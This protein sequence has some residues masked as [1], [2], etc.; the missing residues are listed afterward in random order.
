MA[1]TWSDIIVNN[2][3]VVID[4]VRLTEEL[5]IDAAQF[6]RRM[7]MYFSMAL[8]L[9]SRPPEL[10]QYLTNGLIEA[11]YTDSEWVS[12]AESLEQETEVDTGAVGYELCSCVLRTISAGEVIL[13]PYAVTYDA[14]TGIVTF[15]KQDSEGAEYILDFYTDGKFA[16]DLTETQKRIIGL[17]VAIVWDER[18]TRNWLNMQMKIKD[19]SF[20]TVNESNYLEKT[21]YRM[22]ENRAAFN[23]ELRKYEQD[24]AYTR[25]VPTSLKATNFI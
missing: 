7:A 5:E 3:M 17:A 23:D 4:D 18:F 12:T 14:E 9:V 1:T 6:F 19:S 15:P 10:Y 13:T 16:N 2:A 11:T 21:T 20:D 22:K 24:I 25:V 8:P